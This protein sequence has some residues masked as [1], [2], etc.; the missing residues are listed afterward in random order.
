V[1][2]QTADHAAGTHYPGCGPANVDSLL[3]L[4]VSEPKSKA[5]IVTVGCTGTSWCASFVVVM[6]VEAEV[7]AVVQGARRTG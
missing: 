5:E 7:V 1:R 6:V 3:V 4:S 2:R